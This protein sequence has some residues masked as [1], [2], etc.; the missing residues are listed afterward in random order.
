MQKHDREDMTPHCQILDSG[1]YL[2]PSNHSVYKI[3]IKFNSI[4]SFPHWGSCVLPVVLAFVLVLLLVFVFVLL[5]VFVVVFLLVVVFVFVSL[6]VLP[7]LCTHK[8]FL[9]WRQF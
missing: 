2:L 7:A 1:F 8:G 4:I 9:V 6:L 5:L 3:L